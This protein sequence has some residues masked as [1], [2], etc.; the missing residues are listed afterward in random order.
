MV[1]R[2]RARRESDKGKGK[3]RELLSTHIPN[4]S[5]IGAQ[6]AADESQ[7]V[8]VETRSDMRVRQ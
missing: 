5:R 8:G 1:C 4:D 3:A 2:P 7:H 6:D